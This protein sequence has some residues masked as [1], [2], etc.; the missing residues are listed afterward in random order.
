MRYLASIRTETH[1]SHSGHIIDWTTLKPADQYWKIGRKARLQ[2]NAEILVQD[3]TQ[4]GEPL[5]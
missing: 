3:E 5:V 4:A 1:I 2:T